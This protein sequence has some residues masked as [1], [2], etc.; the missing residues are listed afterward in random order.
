MILYSP[1]SRKAYARLFRAYNDIDVYVED[2]NIVGIYEKLINRSLAGKARVQR[3]I[4]LGP[5]SVVIASARSDNRNDKRPRLYIVDGDLDLTARSRQENIPTLYRLR[6]YSV[7]NLLFEGQAIEKYC[8][9]AHPDKSKTHA[10]SCFKFD[11]TMTELNTYLSPY[12]ILLAIARRENLRNGLLAINAP[13]LSRK[14]KGRYVGVDPG[15]V[16]QRIL[17]IIKY[18]KQ[19]IGVGR[20]RFLKKEIRDGIS[21]RSLSAHQIVPGKE[22]L[23]WY[24]NEITGSAG[25]VSLSQAVIC[26]FLA[27]HCKMQIDKKLASRLKSVARSR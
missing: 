11:E 1:E 14:V 17:L 6:A 12:I 24:L 15:K 26:S 19:S 2:R 27:D 22:F 18:L 10:V 9:F 16:R 13:S 5:R 4:P 23:I 20:Y 3:V 21:R 25:G 7:E 8:S